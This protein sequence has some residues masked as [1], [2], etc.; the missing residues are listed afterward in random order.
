MDE[1]YPDGLPLADYK[2]KFEHADAIAF[3]VR[4]P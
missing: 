2:K 1:I 4:E 3:T